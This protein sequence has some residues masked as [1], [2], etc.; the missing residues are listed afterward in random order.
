MYR[1]ADGK[2]SFLLEDLLSDQNVVTL[3]RDFSCG[4]D[5]GTWKDT[6]FVGIHSIPMPIPDKIIGLCENRPTRNIPVQ[7]IIPLLYDLI[8]YT[9]EQTWDAEA[10]HI[11]FHSSGWDS[12]I[13]SSAIKRLVET[14]GKDWLGKGVLFLSNRWEASEFE[15]IMQIQ[16]WDKSQYWSYTQDSPGEH[17]RSSINVDTV[18]CELNAPSPL[19]GNLW[20][21]LIRNARSVGMIPNCKTQGYSG[22]WANETWDCFTKPIDEWLWRVNNWYSFNVMASLPIAVDII[23]YPLIEASVLEALLKVSNAS[24][25]EL[26]KDVAIY[27]SPETVNIPNRGLSDCNHPLSE[28]LKH[29][30]VT[31]YN[32]M[33]YK[34]V[35]GILAPLTSGL[36]N[37]WAKW[38]MASLCQ[39]LINKGIRI[40][41]V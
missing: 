37:E 24:G 14:N 9:I 2:Q 7:T 3:K 35:T 21:Y 15:A 28:S 34:N 22:Y 6:P 19:P 32:S 41:V 36:S 17:F 5:Q 30:L 8:T 38:N 10:F 1:R 20:V 40:N 18:W 13:I 12:R 29:D 33:W 11:V 25:S 23:E 31:I 16:G 39:H 4:G 26:R 27:A